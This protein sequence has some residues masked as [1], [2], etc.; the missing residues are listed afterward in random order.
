M[1]KIAEIIN[2]DQKRTFDLIR[3]SDALYLSVQ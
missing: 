2:A 1:G 3:E